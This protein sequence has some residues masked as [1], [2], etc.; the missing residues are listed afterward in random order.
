MAD[1]NELIKLREELT[2][3]QDSTR[4]TR[5]R[6]A[7]GFVILVLGLIVCMVYGFMQQVAATKNAE[8]ALRQRIIAEEARVMAERNLEEARRQEAIAK[9][10][11]AAAIIA[12]EEAQ[13]AIEKCKGKK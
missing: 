12:R 6:A 2:Q 11:T 9:E 1:E 8:E 5:R 13:K 3:I 4:R 10:Q 7:F